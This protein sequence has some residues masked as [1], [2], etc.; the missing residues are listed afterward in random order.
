MSAVA[1]GACSYGQ[2]YIDQPV[3]LKPTADVFRPVVEG[4]C[5]LLVT[6]YGSSTVIAPGYAL[7]NAHVT[8]IVD[9]PYIASEY[10]DMAIFKIKGG[11]VAETATEHLGDAT[12]QYGSGCWADTRVAFGHVAYEDVVNCWGDMPSDNPV[13][14]GYGLGGHRGFLVKSD[15]GSGFS[16]GPVLNADGKL[17]GVTEG[18]MMVDGEEFNFCYRIEDAI[19]GFQPIMDAPDKA[20]WSRPAWIDYKLLLAIIL[21]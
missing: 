14:Q 9:T 1:L 19:A 18:T 12:V 20:D 6:E 16:G 13:C 3:P 21:L 10:M 15:G 11:K 5:A 17:I 7:T 8:G 4:S 2:P